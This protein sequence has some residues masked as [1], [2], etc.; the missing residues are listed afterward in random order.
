MKTF[1]DAGATVI[2]HQEGAGKHKGRLGAL[3]V[4]LADGVEFAVGTGLSDKE[5]A[6]PKPFKTN[7]PVATIKTAKKEMSRIK[8][9]YEFIEGASSKFWEIDHTDCNVTTRWGRIGTDGQSKTKTFS[10]E[11]SAQKEYDKL[12]DEKTA[13]GY[14][15]KAPGRNK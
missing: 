8:K 6:A 3:L 1:R 7:T 12:I 5:R 14:V 4:K 15:E 2:G 9:Y 13:K 11:A 10:D